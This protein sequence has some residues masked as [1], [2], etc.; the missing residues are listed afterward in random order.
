[1]VHIKKVLIQGFKSYKDQT[2][3][4]DFHEQVNCIGAS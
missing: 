2:W 3:F 1:M 4:D